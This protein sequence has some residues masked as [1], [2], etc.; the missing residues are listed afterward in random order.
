MA[1][2][3][4]ETMLMHGEDAPQSGLSNLPFAPSRATKQAGIYWQN[5]RP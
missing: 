5:S 1:N 3:L 2:R 4:R